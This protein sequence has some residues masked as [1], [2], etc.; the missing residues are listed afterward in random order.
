MPDGVDVA[1]LLVGVSRR[2]R[3][4]PEERRVAGA[5]VTMKIASPGAGERP[6]V[7]FFQRK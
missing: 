1:H 7:A 4:G 6:P 2:K 3:D 5:N